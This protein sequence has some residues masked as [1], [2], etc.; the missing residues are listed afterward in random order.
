VALA[1]SCSI[2]C[3]RKDPCTT[4]SSTAMVRAHVCCSWPFTL[5]RSMH[6]Y[7]RCAMT[8]WPKV[9]PRALWSRMALGESRRHDCRSPRRP[10]TPLHAVCGIYVARSSSVMQDLSSLR[11]PNR[12]H[13]YA[14]Q[15]QRAVDDAEARIPERGVGSVTANSDAPRV[16]II[17]EPGLLRK[18]SR[19]WRE[20]CGPSWSGTA[21]PC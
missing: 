10:P 8:P 6:E 20:S 5:V 4:T 18:T 9:A 3:V 11:N 15:L 2:C 1:K 17:C 13:M 14:L 21:T 19:H 12:T 7:Y 16:C